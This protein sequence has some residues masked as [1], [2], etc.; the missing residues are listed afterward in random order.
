MPSPLFANALIAE[1][2]ITLDEAAIN[3]VHAQSNRPP[4]ALTPTFEAFE[5]GWAQGR[6]QMV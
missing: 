3:A 1:A 6:N 2:G 5:R 4:M